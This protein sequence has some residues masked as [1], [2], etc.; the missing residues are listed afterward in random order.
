MS[1]VPKLKRFNK[2]TG[3]PKWSIFLYGKKNQAHQRVPP[4]T[5][6]VE[7]WEKNILQWKPMELGGVP[8]K[9]DEYF[10]W[11]PI[12]YVCSSARN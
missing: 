3:P 8:E 9:M 1:E 10:H 7:L 6:V 12:F 4:T 5:G 11:G 2:K